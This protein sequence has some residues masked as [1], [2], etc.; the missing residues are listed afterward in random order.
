MTKIDGKQ[1]AITI[2]DEIAVEVAQLK[3]DGGKTPHLA[4][5]LVGAD[6]A[7]QVY[8]R[9]KV[10]ACEKVGF[11]S[12]LIEREAST[13]E[14]ELLAIVAELN[15]DEDIDGFIVQLPLPKHINEEAITLAI[16]PS[17]D[18]DGF[19]PINFGRMALGLPCYLPATPF[20]IMQMLDRYNICLLY[21]S[22]SPRDATLSRMPSSA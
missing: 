15:R 3:A 1:L 17:K 16:K 9:N 18:V 4:A 20:G 5:V 22:P 8:V 21:T 13:T 19:H 10:I 11:K 2:K 6:P 12:T 14:E 7:S